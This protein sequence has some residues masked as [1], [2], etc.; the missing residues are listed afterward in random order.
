MTTGSPLR[1][2]RVLSVGINP[3][4]G[5]FL[6]ALAV[7][8]VFLL[9]YGLDA[10]LITWGDDHEYDEIA[11]DIVAGRPYGNVWFP[12]GYPVFLAAV[13]ALFSPSQV[14]VRLIQSLIGA[15]T[16]V[17]TYSVGK[18]LLDERA[19]LTAAIFFSVY[20]AHVYMSWRTMAEVLYTFL[21]ALSV[22]WILELLRSPRVSRALLVGV[23]LGAANVVKSNLIVLTPVLLVWLWRRLAKRPPQQRPA[24]LALLGSCLVVSLITPAANYLAS[25]GEIAPLAGNAGHTFWWSNN[26]AADGYFLDPDP[27]PEAQ[28][29][30]ESHA[31]GAAVD[32]MSHFERD[33]FYFR[34][35][36]RWIRENPGEFA[37]LVSHKLTNAF[38]PVPRTAVF[39][40]DSLAARVHKAW[41][42]PAAPL[43]LL[44]I[45]VS[46]RERRDLTILYLILASYLVVTILYYGTPR[47]TVIIGP[48]LAI[49]SGV[50]LVRVYAA[51]KRFAVAMAE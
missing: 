33:R 34:L 35:A 40:K 45:F 2:A 22:L 17:V 50:G 12:P 8:V 19:G 1:R 14:A 20:P 28:A 47:F 39:T 11:R 3:A 43:V 27:A 42:I 38:G 51:A 21:L 37:T 46:L 10:P 4:I 7:R 29:F 32:S 18:R 24:I 13:Y 36:L 41:F 5:V 48:W 49:L 30:L 26:P 44:G 9:A 16:C 15:A 23:T 31:T 25:R 6:L